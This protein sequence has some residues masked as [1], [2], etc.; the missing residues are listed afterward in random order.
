[1]RA[2]RRENRDPLPDRDRS[3]GRASKQEGG[4]RRDDLDGCRGS[5]IRVDDPYHPALSKIPANL[6]ERSEIPVTR[7]EKV[8]PF[9]LDAHEAGRRSSRCASRPAARD[10]GAGA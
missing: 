8:A 5:P 2:V 7:R 9:R 10:A 3:G 4:A 1:M 6:G